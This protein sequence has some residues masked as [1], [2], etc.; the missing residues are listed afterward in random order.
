MVEAA[1]V[2][3]FKGNED[4]M[5]TTG[6]GG[7]LLGRGSALTSENSHGVSTEGGKQAEDGGVGGCELHE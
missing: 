2:D 4:V 6:V 5:C 3:I 7:L 1:A